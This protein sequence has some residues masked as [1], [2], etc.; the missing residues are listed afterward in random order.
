MFGLHSKPNVFVVALALA[1]AMT[2]YFVL[3]KERFVAS[4]SSAIKDAPLDTLSR[5]MKALMSA[6]RIG[7]QEP[8]SKGYVT[9]SSNMFA[10]RDVVKRGLEE[11]FAAL[12]KNTLSVM[13][14][15][16]SLK[17]KQLSSDGLETIV[18][19]MVFDSKS[20][21]AFRIRAKVLLKNIRWLGDKPTASTNVVFLR[22]ADTEQTPS[23]QASPPGLSS[24][25]SH[26]TY[27]NALHLGPPFPSALDDMA[28]SESM[29]AD[30]QKKLANDP[31]ILR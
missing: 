20:F 17:H 12:G 27:N 31:K 10:Y 8:D 28:I 4:N 11:R 2:L 18:E 14:A 26:F 19:T 5:E 1:I 25:P 29:H 21:V 7:D 9:V 3:Q 24:N 13:P 30:F 6:L 15:F 16:D 22:V 23:S